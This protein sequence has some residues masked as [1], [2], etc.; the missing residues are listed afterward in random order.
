M[1]K[2]PATRSR[3]CFGCG[4]LA[5]FVTLDRNSLQTELT[6]D[7]PTGHQG[8]EVV[9]SVVAV[10][11]VVVAERVCPPMIARDCCR[12]W[13]TP[14]SKRRHPVGRDDIL[15]PPPDSFPVHTYVKVSRR[16]FLRESYANQGRTLAA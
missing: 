11:G 6:F 4:T 1:R 16:E 10:A 5:V 13:R 2:S 14:V 3:H 7:V 9:S 8:A 12:A 15:L